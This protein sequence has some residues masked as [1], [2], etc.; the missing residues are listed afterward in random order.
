MRWACFNNSATIILKKISYHR[1]KRITASCAWPNAMSQRASFEY[2]SHFSLSFVTFFDQF[3]LTFEQVSRKWCESKR[4]NETP[5][6]SIQP[7][8][9]T[10]AC[11]SQP[12]ILQIRIYPLSENRVTGS[13]P[14][15]AFLNHFATV[16]WTCFARKLWKR[17]PSTVGWTMHCTKV[18]NESS[19]MCTAPSWLMSVEKTMQDTC[20]LRL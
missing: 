16:L 8:N 20:S 1:G 7:I 15:L 12:A 17:D 9:K 19:P 2:D 11:D 5:W 6:R 10:Q 3:F 13:L 18:F 4:L 14:S